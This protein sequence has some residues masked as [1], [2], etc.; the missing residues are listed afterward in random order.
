MC[1]I[2]FNFFRGC[3]MEHFTDHERRLS[4]LERQLSQQKEACAQVKSQLE[5][6]KAEALQKQ[7]DLTELNHPNFFQR[8]FGNLRKKRDDAWAA[9]QEA[10][11]A[12]EQ[13]KLD[14]AEQQDRLERLQAEY[15]TL[16]SAK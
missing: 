2:Q 6:A 15:Q 14:V 3:F 9:Y 5:L 11:L 8:R 4:S 7:F 13:A 10:V 1:Y 16:L 12:L